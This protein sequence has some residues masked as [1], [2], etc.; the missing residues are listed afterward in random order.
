MMLRYRMYCTVARWQ[1]NVI[2]AGL[3]GLLC[4]PL[5]PAPTRAQDAPPTGSIEACLAPHGEREQYLAGLIA[6]GWR[7]LPPDGRDAALAMLADAYLPV[8][9]Q[10]D[11]TWAD[12]LANRESALIFWTDLAQNRTLM[13]REGFV[14]LLAGFRD[15]DDKMRVECWTAGPVSPVTD[16][17]FAL[18]GAVYQSEGVTMTQVNLPATDDR[19]ATELFVSRLTPPL[20]VDPPLAATD[21]LRTR[22]VF[23]MQEGA[24]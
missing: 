11:G 18:I 9:G 6:T 23:A 16:D 1:L 15:D 21:G 12:H 2:R 19:P 14:L 10:I 8:T 20:A 24:R 13:Q 7:D 22:I 5:G 17:F 3:I 4:L